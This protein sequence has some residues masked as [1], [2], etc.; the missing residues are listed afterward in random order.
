MVDNEGQQRPEEGDE[1]LDVKVTRPPPSTL[2]LLQ[3]LSQLRE[4]ESDS[5]ILQVMDTGKNAVR[6]CTLPKYGT[7]NV[8]PILMDL[9]KEY[10][11][12]SWVGTPCHSI[13]CHAIWHGMGPTNT[14]LVAGETS[15]R[16]KDRV[17]TALGRRKRRMAEVSHKQ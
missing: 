5:F 6:R 4:N 3:P 7:S 10:I 12:G 17:A 13:P 8:L 15:D 16:A 11:R 2:L 9:Q 1:C 14:R